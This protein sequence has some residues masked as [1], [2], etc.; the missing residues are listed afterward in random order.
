MGVLINVLI[1]FIVLVG[2]GLIFI[3]KIKGKFIIDFMRLKLGDIIDIWN[4]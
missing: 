2:K 3:Y 1:L 4:I